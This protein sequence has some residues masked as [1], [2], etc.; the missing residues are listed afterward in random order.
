MEKQL[1]YSDIDA[2]VIRGNK[3]LLLRCE[4]ELAARAIW[5]MIKPNEIIIDVVLQPDKCYQV[6]VRIPS[7][8]KNLGVVTAN[9]R[10]E[11][12]E[13]QMLE[14]NQ[15]TH[16][17]TCYRDNERRWT[18]VEPLVLIHPPNQHPN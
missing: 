14:G 16:V 10:E 11:R 12:K 3:T 2:Q 18:N 15:L 6:W 17:T 1:T 13:L 8:R 7:M 4:N 5:A 9:T